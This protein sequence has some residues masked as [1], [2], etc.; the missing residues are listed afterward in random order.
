MIK[1][2][3][4]VLQLCNVEDAHFHYINNYPMMMFSFQD[5]GIEN[6]LYY[7]DFVHKDFKSIARRIEI[8]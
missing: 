5:Y 7:V 3:S 8:K 2:T 6:D 1:M 4:S